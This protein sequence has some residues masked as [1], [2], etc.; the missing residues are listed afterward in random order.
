[1]PDDQLLATAKWHC[2][3]RN[4][5]WV[6]PA[7]GCRK[8]LADPTTVSC[9]WKS[10]VYINNVQKFSSDHAVYKSRGSGIGAAT[11]PRMVGKG[12]E[13]RWKLGIFF[14]HNV[15]TGSGAYLK[16]YFQNMRTKCDG[17][18]SQCPRSLRR[19]STVSR[20]LGLW[21]RIPPEAWMS[22]SCECC[23]LSGRDLWDGL[24]TRPEESYQVWCVQKVWSWSLE[25]WGGL[26]PQGA[27]DP[28]EKKCDSQ[29]LFLKN[30]VPTA[31]KTPLNAIWKNKSMIIVLDTNTVCERLPSFTVKIKC[32]FLL[33]CL[34]GISEKCCLK[35][36]L[37]RKVLLVMCQNGIVSIELARSTDKY[38]R[39][40]CVV[41]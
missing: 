1:V 21:V 30:S 32:V 17:R 38:W 8:T 36:K 20:L 24:I 23:V 25:K 11:R 40:C 13:S 16:A 14:L 22:V 6:R 19:R 18:R 35:V 33:L 9:F 29:R 34:R 10:E 15:Q 5:G 7:K 39:S 28:L 27:V 12:F 26:G 4:T 37:K 2:I 31:N 3:V 41:V